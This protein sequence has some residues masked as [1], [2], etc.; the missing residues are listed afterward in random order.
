M[1]HPLAR[2]VA[3]ACRRPWAVLG[4]ALLLTVA[5]GI[6]VSQR[7]AM[8]TDA[9]QLI[10]PK[11]DWRLNERRMDAAFPQNGDTLLV[12][13]DGATPE[14]AEAFT[15]ALFQRMAADKAHFRRVTRPDGGDYFA[16][17]GLLFGSMDDV[18]AATRQ[19]TAAQPLL[20]PLAGDPSLRGIAGAL[21]TMLTGVQRGQAELA[22]IDKPVASL[23][24]ALDAQSKGKPAFFSW[25]ALLAGDGKGALSAPKRRL[26]LATPVLDYGS[27]MPGEPASD[28]VRGYVKALN[29]DAAHGAR[30]RLTGSVPLSDEEFASLEDHAWLVGASMI[31][32]MVVTLRLAVRSWRIVGAILGTTIAGLVVTAAIGLAA[33]GRF[34]LISVAFIPLF[35]GL[36]VD[37]GIQLGV[38]FQAERLDH[39]N[40]AQAMTAAA[41]A[42]AGPL[43]LAAG[44]VCLGFFAFLPTDYVGIA[45]LGV[46]A[47]I[48]MVIALIFA[49]TLL[50]ALL[51]LL[52]PGAPQAELGNPKLAWLDDLLLR[53]RKLVLALFGLSM[54]LSIA[55]LFWVRFDFNPFHLRNPNFEALA[56]LNELMADP[57]RDPNTIDILMPNLPAAQALA[58][59]LSRLPEVGHAITAASFVPADQAPKLAAIGNAQALLDFSLNPFAPALPAS[60][61]DTI[62]ALRHTAQGL[63]QTA[64][65]RDKP[66]AD[67]RRL[68]DAF[69]HLAGAA[70]DARARATTLLVAPLNG[71][72]DQMRN[73]LAAQPVTVVTLP[74]AVKQDWIAKDGQ[75]R[76][77]LTAAPAFRGSDK[78]LARF[79][80]AVRKIAP[81]ATGTA[82]STQAAARTVAKAFVQAGALA[83]VVVSLLLLAVLRSAREVA[84]TLAPVVL[85]GFLTLGTCVLIGQPI[86]FANIIAFPL[87]FGVGVAFHIYFVMAWRAG[88]TELLQS[89]LARAVFFSALATGSAFGSLWLSRH[90]GTASMGKIL[91]LSLAWTLVCALIFEPA[92][93]GPQK[94]KGR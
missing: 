5:A 42:L 3:F 84:F 72:L 44:A 69:D 43:L 46:I 6:F 15:A 37:F 81:D 47:G 45:E 65:G 64:S 41:V 92:L 18:N 56:T 76:I 32:F 34:N 51:M 68:A 80:A 24:D 61:A 27:L 16:R 33:V 70:P 87:L 55:S 59:K 60:D 50:P 8:T 53:K 35:V 57:D 30:V 7:F 26:I 11:V 49:V 20:G 25:Q 88:A 36:G 10:S 93:L 74:E 91:M 40:R 58:A 14:I 2:L 67:A 77:Q 31:L 94:R 75:A 83:L 78:G 85:S 1:T 39:A 54:L 79:V 4:I 19:M 29:L 66:S 71:M 86:N 22:D 62:A 52:R 90:P 63:R 13:V 17:E 48:G 21:D 28:A 23:A 9:T 89:P 73:A 12:V 38:R 82:V